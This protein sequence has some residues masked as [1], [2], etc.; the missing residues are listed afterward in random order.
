MTDQIVTRADTQRRARAAFNSGLSIAEH[1]PNWHSAA[2]E[3]WADVYAQLE[4]EETLA[5]A[6]HQEQ[7]A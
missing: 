6:Q 5:R 2:Y 3:V 7:A 1:G 4:A